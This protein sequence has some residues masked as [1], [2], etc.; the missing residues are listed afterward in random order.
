MSIKYYFFYQYVLH[1]HVG[2]HICFFLS[3]LCFFICRRF[4]IKWVA[5]K[6][7][8][9]FGDARGDIILSHDY[10][11]FT[12]SSV[13]F[14]LYTK[15]QTRYRDEYLLNQK[16]HDVKTSPRPFIVEGVEMDIRMRGFE[17]FSLISPYTF[18][19][20]RPMHLKATGRVRFQGKM[21]KPRYGVDEEVPGVGTTVK[22]NNHNLAGEVTISGLKLNQLMLAPQLVG[23]LSIS[24]E[25]VKVFCFKVFCCVL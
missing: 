2:L 5:P 24:P 14:E 20:L 25:C 16:E 23:S 15:F 19:S 22:D 4:D 12:S 18:D 17:F 6:A 3:F 10:I 8:G 9:S 21:V 11:M 13:A 7:E 1:V